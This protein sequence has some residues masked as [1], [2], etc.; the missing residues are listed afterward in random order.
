M[1]AAA[2]Q[3]A[4]E[5]DMT[6]IRRHDKTLELI[7]CIADYLDLYG[8]PEMRAYDV[9]VETVNGYLDEAIKGATT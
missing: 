3:L 9:A 1:D 4:D 6:R 8:V 5:T 7:D 2:R